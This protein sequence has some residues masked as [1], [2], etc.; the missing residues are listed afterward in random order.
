MQMEQTTTAYELFV[1]AHSLYTQRSAEQI[2]A[3]VRPDEFERQLRQLH[4]QWLNGT[5]SFGKFTEIIGVAHAELWDI[6]AALGLVLH[7]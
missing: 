4:S 3:D 1:E 2:R 6:L 5:F 7:R